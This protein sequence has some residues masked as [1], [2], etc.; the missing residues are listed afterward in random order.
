M[1]LYNTFETNKDLERDGITLDYGFNDKNEP[2]QI[3]IARA[4]GSNTRF[5]KILEQKMRPYKRAI[6]TDSLDNQVAQQLMIEAYADA[7]ILGW[8]GVQDRD[9]N[10]LDF[11]RENVVKVLTDLPDLFY[12]IQAQSQKAAL[13]REDI[14]ATEAGNSLGS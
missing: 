7:V 13:F 12:D 6:A 8:T 11:N 3:R 1:N 2:I 10:V 4:G 5:A 9:G 14:R